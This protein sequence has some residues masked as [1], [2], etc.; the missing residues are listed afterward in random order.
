MIKKFKFLILLF[1]V[2]GGGLFGQGGKYILY[3][4]ESNNVSNLVLY[5]TNTSETN[6]LTHF[7]NSGKIESISVDETRLKIIFTRPSP[8]YGKIN[9]TIWMM[10]Y[11]GSGLCD[12]I[13]GDTEIDFKY[14]AISPDG[15]KIAY[16]ANS[17]SVPG[18]YQLYV[19]DTTTKISNQLTNF[20]PPVE[21]SYPSFI[22][23]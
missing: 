14:A 20:Q 4:Q 12:L 5:D 16:C 22:N 8:S 19:M 9:S 10:N 17:L 11:D 6:L 21:C 23:N 15:E 18:S 3:V 7:Q 2:G 1:I 13:E